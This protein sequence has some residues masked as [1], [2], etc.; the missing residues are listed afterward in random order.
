MFD[1]DDREYRQWAWGFYSEMMHADGARV[2]SAGWKS[3]DQSS[4]IS[5]A[6]RKYA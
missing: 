1:P 2:P 5:V 6:V 4:S 3:E